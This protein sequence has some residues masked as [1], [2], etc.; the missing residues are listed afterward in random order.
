MTQPDTTRLTEMIEARAR[1]LRELASDME[2]ARCAYAAMDL[3]AIYGHVAAQR[4]ICE[5]LQDLERN[6]NETAG[7]MHGAAQ[8][9]LR[10]TKGDEKGARAMSLSAGDPALA[11]RLRRALAEMAAAERQARQT[12][13]AHV[14]ILE[15]TR[16]TIQTMSN[17]LMMFSAV[18]SR[19]PQTEAIGANH[20]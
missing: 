11:Q 9:G 15:G 20:I 17:A 4:A 3:E 2:A 12:H 5:Q 16:R 18:Y 14:L 7:D 19:P 10:T 8:A 13:R 6:R 1:L